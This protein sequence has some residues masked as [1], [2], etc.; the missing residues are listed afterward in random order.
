M[1]AL[2]EITELIQKW[3]LGDSLSE[4]RLFS[5]TYQQF[6]ILAKKA[7]NK[8]SN[9]QNNLED[10]VHS[11]TSLVH[12]AYIKLSHANAIDITNRKDFYLLTAKT[13]RHI[14]VDYFRKKNSQKRYV[15]ISTDVA[16]N[17]I[18][19]TNNF[20]QYLILD[21]AIQLLHDKHPRP[22]DI[23]QLKHFFGFANK[24]IANLLNIS[25]STVD[26]DLKFARSLIKLTLSDA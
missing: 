24:E 2:V 8:Q 1:G 3:K 11:T 20:E 9:S 7:I 18:T 4:D 12:D 25:E 19:H 5:V 21:K 10:I 17:D 13:M 26:K 16:L 22:G 23:L 14:L 6:K 15:D